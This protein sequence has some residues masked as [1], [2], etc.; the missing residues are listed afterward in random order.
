MKYTALLFGLLAFQVEAQ[1]GLTPQLRSQFTLEH[2]ASS[3]GLSNSDIMYGVPIAPGQVVGN[4][5]L[6]E[7]W[8]K[9]SLQLSQSEK[10]LEG[11]YVRYNLKEN[12]IEIRSGGRVKLI[13]ADKVKALVWIDSVTSLPSYF[14]FGGNYQY[15][16]SKLS[17]LLQVLVDGSVPLLKHIR[18]EIKSP[19]YNVATGAGS[20]DTKIIKKVQYLSLQQGTH[21]N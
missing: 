1:T 5:Y 11:F 9:A 13:S 7:K 3:N 14:V 12:G 10:P 17:T 4:V 6:D 16:Q 20:K 15:Q 18:L 8:N 21:S 2:L 19:T